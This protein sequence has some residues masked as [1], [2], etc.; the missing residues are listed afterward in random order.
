LE[1]PCRFRTKGGLN[2]HMGRH[3]T[4]TGPGRL[5]HPSVLDRVLEQISEDLHQLI[6][7]TGNVQ[8]LISQLS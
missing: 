7:I 1:K 4:A 8:R 5:R 2:E 3:Q 6:R